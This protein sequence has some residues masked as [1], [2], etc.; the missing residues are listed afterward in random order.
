V[1]LTAADARALKEQMHSA[2]QAEVLAAGVE[3]VAEDIAVADKRRK[4]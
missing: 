1:K 2:G 3:L 4:R